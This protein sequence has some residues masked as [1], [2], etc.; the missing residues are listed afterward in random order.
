MSIRFVA[1]DT[2]LVKRLQGG[3]VDANGHK[4]EPVWLQRL[5]AGRFEDD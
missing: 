3:G 2:E 4:P 5:K 1:L